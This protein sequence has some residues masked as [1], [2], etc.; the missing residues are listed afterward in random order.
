MSTKQLLTCSS[1][2]FHCR[3]EVQLSAEHGSLHSKIPIPAT[4]TPG[5]YSIELLLPTPVREGDGDSFDQKDST[6]FAMTV[7]VVS[8]ESDGSTDLM[9]PGDEKAVSSSRVY[10]SG[11]AGSSS[12]KGMEGS[13]SVASTSFVI[14]DP[15]PPTAD[16][17]LEAPTWVR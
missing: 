12:R 5:S 4:A 2:V 13:A 1:P 11:V 9:G 7:A 8:R 10:N 16:L 17:T 6:D 15:R 3:I 14:A